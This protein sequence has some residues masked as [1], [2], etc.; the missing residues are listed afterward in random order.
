[1]PLVGE[2]RI[3]VRYGL[4]KLA[5]SRWVGL[6]ALIETAG[7]G[8][9][10]LRGRTSGSFWRAAQRRG[11]IGD[12]TRPAPAAHEDP[13]EAAKLAASS[14]RSMRDAKRWIT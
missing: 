4:K 9:K 6:R 7:L 1:V 3:L 12:A 11:R 13:Q 8:G 5:N 10:P 2:N 14:R